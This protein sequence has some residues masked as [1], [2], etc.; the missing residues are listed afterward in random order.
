MGQP[1]KDKALVGKTRWGDPIYTI[2]PSVPDKQGIVTKRKSKIG[3]DRRGIIINDGTG[4]I[5]GDGSATYYEFEEVDSERFV[6]L[7]LAGVKKAADLSKA[8]LSVFEWI[9]MQVMESPNTDRVN[10]S[11]DDPGI[12]MARTTFYRGLRELLD[13]DFLF[14]TPW[15]GTYF[16]NVRY[17]FNGDRLAFVKG[18][19][20]KQAR[21]AKARATSIAKPTKEQETP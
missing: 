21:Q 18:Y 10:L 6:K 1:P 12:L 9:Y 14:R 2:N 16:I 17:L 19:Q 8:G 3:N 11:V 15:E 7:Y 4:E 20:R 13:R 5:L